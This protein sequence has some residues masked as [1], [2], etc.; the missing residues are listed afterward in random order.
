MGK[1]VFGPWTMMARATSSDVR[2][3]T[4]AERL[5]LRMSAASRRCVTW[6]G[7]RRAVACLTASY[8]LCG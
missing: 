2:Q 7:S 5:L 4:Y 6:K 1:W 8:G 3:G